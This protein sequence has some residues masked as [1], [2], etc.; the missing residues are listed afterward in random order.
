MTRSLGLPK[1][2]LQS[3]KV[4]GERIW[5]VRE[6]EQGVMRDIRSRV[7]YGPTG[8]ACVEEGGQGLRARGAE[9]MGS[10]VAGVC[11]EQSV[12]QSA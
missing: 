6:P 1:A 5:F 10:S 11:V 7:G 4:D 9:I 2:L 8:W 12:E 3:S